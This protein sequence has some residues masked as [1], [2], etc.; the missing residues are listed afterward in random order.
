MGMIAPSMTGVVPVTDENNRYQ[1]SKM[2]R[3]APFFLAS[4]TQWE[5]NVKRYV[6]DFDKIDG[7]V[8]EF[9]A[10]DLSGLPDQELWR[11][12]QGVWLVRA[13]H[14]MRAHSN[15]TSLSL[16]AYTQLEEFSGRWMGDR[17]LAPRLA[18]GISG[19]IAAGIVPSLWDLARQLRQLGLADIVLHQPPRDALAE[20]RKTPV[21]GPV[22]LRFDAFLRHGHRCISEAEWLHPA[23]SKRQKW[24]WSQLAVTCVRAT[25]MILLEQWPVQNKRGWQL[26]QQSS[27]A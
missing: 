25:A 24:S 17:S 14:Y 21:A 10:R 27:S 2:L 4:M 1:W 22:M 19:V 15:A 18:G 12:A 9:M 6:A 26:R 3:H 20:L 7:W 13:M 8:G 16:T 23:G 5:N 11:E